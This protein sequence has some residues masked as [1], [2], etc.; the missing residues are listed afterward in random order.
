LSHVAGS[1]R[2]VLLSLLGV[3][4]LLGSA[5]CS[6]SPSTPTAAIVVSDAWVQVTG[7]SALPA[8][9]YF[10]IDNRG[11][12]DDTLLS[13]SSPGATLVE[14][15]QTGPEMS[16]MIGM[17]AVASVPCSAHATVTFA[18]GG[19]HLMLSGLVAQLRTGDHVELDLV[20]ARAGTIVVQAAV[21]QV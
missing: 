2:R 20:F 17:N 15:H 18:P 1:G 3:L 10:T 8:A 6:G 21:R 14:L 12:A 16:G 13:A 11:D 19:Y 9:G 5:G 4:A 7:G